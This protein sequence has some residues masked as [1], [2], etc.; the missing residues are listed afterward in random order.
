MDDEKTTPGTISRTGGTVT[1]GCSP[2]VP[3][4]FA[5]TETVSAIADAGRRSPT[6]IDPSND[7]ERK[8]QVD[9]NTR[10]SNP[11]LTCNLALADLAPDLQVFVRHHSVTL[12]AVSGAKM[13]ETGE[14]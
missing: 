5:S 1:S 10:I 2:N 6:K 4:A 9:M 7:L 3:V 11:L 8:P 13:P 12:P 14:R